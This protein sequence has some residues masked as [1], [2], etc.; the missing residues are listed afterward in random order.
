MSECTLC[1]REAPQH[2]LG[3]IRIEQ[4]DL[5]DAQLVTL[6]HMAGPKK[7]EKP[8]WHEEVLIEGTMRTEPVET[9]DPEK[10]EEPPEPERPCAL[11]GCTNEVT[12]D[13]RVKYCE[14]HKDP[15]NR[16]E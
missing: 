1:G 3:C 9:A 2:H 16:K 5:T 4:P 12:G 6:G 8:V 14:D 13:K 7:A 15:K 11:E 10:T